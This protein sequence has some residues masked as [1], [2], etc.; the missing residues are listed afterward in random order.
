[1]TGRRLADVYARHLA[2][3]LRAPNAHPSDAIKGAMLVLIRERAL[4]ALAPELRR[5]SIAALHEQLRDRGWSCPDGCTAC[6]DE[7]E[8]KEQA[9]RDELGER[10]YCR[11]AAYHGVKCPDGHGSE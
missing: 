2:D 9:E 6:A 10:A 1:M 4:V 3:V 5:R 11:A 8:A 7:Y